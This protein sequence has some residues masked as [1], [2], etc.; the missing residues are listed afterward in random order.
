[1]TEDAV[2]F[3]LPAFFYII[4]LYM[5]YDVEWLLLPLSKFWEE[6]PDWALKVSSDLDSRTKLLLSLSG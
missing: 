5:S 6:D 4:F 3:G 1:M 2:F